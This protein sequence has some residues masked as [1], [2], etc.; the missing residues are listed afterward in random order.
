[1]DE[2]EKRWEKLKDKET[3]G[4]KKRKEDY[5]GFKLTLVTQL[6]TYFSINKTRSSKFPYQFILEWLGV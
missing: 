3:R 5:A 1:M 4:K 6:F 2:V